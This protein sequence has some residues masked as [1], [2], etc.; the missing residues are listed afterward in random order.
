MNNKKQKLI[1][2]IVILILAFFGFAKS[3]SA[4]YYSS[5][6]FVSIN[7]L[8]GKTVISIDS[9]VYNLS[10]KPTETGAT[11]QFSQDNTNWHNSIGILDGTDTL[12]PSL[13]LTIL[14]VHSHPQKGDDW[15]VSFE[16]TGTADLTITPEDQ[17]TIDDLDFVSLKCSGSTSDGGAPSGDDSSEVENYVQPQIL[18][19]DV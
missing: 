17:A 12:D 11:I 15:V 7:L 10:A 2:F 3:A 6:N 19:N 18:A 1:I 8:E 14:T 9:F 16:T 13:Q 5:G 4:N